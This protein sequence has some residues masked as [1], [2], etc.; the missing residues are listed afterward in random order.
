MLAKLILFLPGKR[1]T[2]WDKAVSAQNLSKSSSSW[3]LFFQSD[4]RTINDLISALPDK[5]PL[6]LTTYVRYYFS[7]HNQPVNGTW[8]NTARSYDLIGI[9]KDWQ[10]FFNLQYST[11]FDLINNIP[12]SGNEKKVTYTSYYLAQH[13]EIRNYRLWK[14]GA[15]SYDLAETDHRWKK[16]VFSKFDSPRELMAAVDGYVSNINSR[17]SPVSYFRMYMGLH[18][19]IESSGDWINYAASVAFARNNKEAFNAII[20]GELSVSEAISVYDLTQAASTI[21]KYIRKL[22]QFS[23]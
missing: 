4:Y 18:F 6:K 19:E 1:S 13:P 7:F 22:K 21:D 3:L 20:N 8:L 12:E 14:D 16:I 9:S 15:A 2:E 11:P 5:A 17:K 23:T 10:Q